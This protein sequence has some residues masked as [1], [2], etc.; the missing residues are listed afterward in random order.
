MALLLDCLDFRR[1]GAFDVGEN[2]V[3][4]LITQDTAKRWHIAFESLWRCSLTAKLN[5][6]EE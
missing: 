5:C 3:Y 1:P 4:F 2:C 6:C